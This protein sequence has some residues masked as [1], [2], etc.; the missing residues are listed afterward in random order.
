MRVAVVIPAHNE[1]ASL[2]R[3]LD[4]IPTGLVE[5]VVVVDNA[6]TDGTAAVARSRGATLVEERRRGYGAA[7]QAGI[8][9][10]RRKRPD[11]VVFL[12][13]DFSDDPGEMAGLLAPLARGECDLVIGSRTLGRRERGALRPQ[14]IAGNWLATRLIRIL[15]GSRF[16]DLVPFRAIRFERLCALGMQDRG[17]GWTVEMQVKAAK[18]GMRTAEIPVSYR[19]RRE[20]ASKVTGSLAGSFRAGV[21]ILRTILRHL[22]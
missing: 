15:Y 1:E 14:A 22:G 17:S 19:R 8:D 16:T 11:A 5:E 2:P 12:D 10:L 13:A 7:C 9:Y 6:S 20:G 18:E 3:V 4:A 21:A